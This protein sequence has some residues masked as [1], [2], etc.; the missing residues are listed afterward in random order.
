MREGG[1]L[2][3]FIYNTMNRYMYRKFCKR[4]DKYFQNII[5]PIPSNYSEMSEL[6]FL[7]KFKII[8]SFTSDTRASF[9]TLSDDSSHTTKASVFKVFL[10]FVEQ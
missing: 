3:K 7:W 1:V 10:R 5:D 8:K 2:I 6:E 4:I 9:D